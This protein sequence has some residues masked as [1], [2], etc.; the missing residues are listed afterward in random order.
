MNCAEMERDT[1]FVRLV[2]LGA[3]PAEAVLRTGCPAAG[4]WRTGLLEDR[5]E[6]LEVAGPEVRVPLE[7]HRIA[8][9][10]IDLSVRSTAG[11]P[12]GR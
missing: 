7:P 6:A 1:L 3:E 5:R 4:A 11:A 12:S 2:N 10:E 9:V 8:G